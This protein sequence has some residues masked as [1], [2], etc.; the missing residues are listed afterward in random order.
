MSD[1]RHEA[2]CRFEDPELFF[3]PSPAA[4][5]SSKQQTEEAKSVCRRCPVVDKCLAWAYE[6]N[7]EAGVLGGLS[8]NERRAFKRRY[9]RL[10]NLA[11]NR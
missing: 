2:A 9:T 3:P 4:S 7:Q 5:A 1:W 10:G 8:E 6:T 11:T